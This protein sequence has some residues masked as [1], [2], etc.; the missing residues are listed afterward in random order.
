MPE[1][2]GRTA[3]ARTRFSQQKNNTY[4]LFSLPFPYHPQPTYPTAS[5]QDTPTPSHRDAATHTAP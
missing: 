2:E 4:P 5:L 1:P 3:R